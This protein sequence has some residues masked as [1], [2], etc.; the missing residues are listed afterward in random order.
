MYTLYFKVISEA[1][2]F[3]RDTSD[4]LCEMT[5]ISVK[6][7]YSS[8]LTYESVHST[9]RSNRNSLYCSNNIN[10]AIIYFRFKFKSFQMV[11]LR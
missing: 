9:F 7:I 3:K 2:M 4:N 5:Y 10:D 8:I 11:G 1:I 6:R